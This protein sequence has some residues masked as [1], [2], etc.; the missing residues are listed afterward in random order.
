MTTAEITP[1]HTASI[2]ARETAHDAAHV[3]GDDRCEACGHNFPADARCLHCVEPRPRS[4]DS[5]SASPPMPPLV[6]DRVSIVGTTITIDLMHS[7]GDS[8]RVVVTVEIPERETDKHFDT[9]LELAAPYHKLELVKA[10]SEDVSHADHP[11]A[12]DLLQCQAEVARLTAHLADSDEALS[13]L[14]DDR[15]ELEYQVAKYK[16][17]AAG[18]E[19]ERQRLWDLIR[20][21]EAQLWTANTRAQ[22]LE[23]ELTDAQQTITEQSSVLDMLAG[24]TI[25]AVPF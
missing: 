9:T 2:I 21:R 22:E 15:S 16:E 12:Q 7:A 10:D 20:A 5:P 1:D 19:R 14:D 23:T 18:V 11:A 25:A 3:H 13:L 24:A 8:A 6:V 4:I 17:V